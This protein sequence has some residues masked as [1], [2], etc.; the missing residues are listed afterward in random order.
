M[1]QS[2]LSLRRLATRL[3]LITQVVSQH[4][5]DAAASALWAL[6]LA[7]TGT[8]GSRQALS[9]AALQGRHNHAPN[10]QDPDGFC[11]FSNTVL[12]TFLLF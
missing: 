11:P 9:P 1:L 2:S 4:L 8:R 10:K 7:V 5:G 6:Y 12:L 3:K